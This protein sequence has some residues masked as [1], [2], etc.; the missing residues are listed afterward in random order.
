MSLPLATPRFVPARDVTALALFGAAMVTW[1]WL[2]F[3]RCV[4]IG[5]ELADASLAFQCCPTENGP[6]VLFLGDS[7]AVGCGAARPEDSIAGLLAQDF[8]HVTI[9]NRGCNGARTVEALAQLEAEPHPSYDAILIN[10]GGNDILKRTPFHTLPASAEALVAAARQRSE[11][12]IVTTTPNIG[13]V[14]M[15]FAPLSWW[16]TRRSRQLR[17]LFADVCKRHGA[18]YVNFFHP[19]SSDPFHREGRRFYAPDGLHPSTDCYRYVYATLRAG[20]PLA[21]VLAR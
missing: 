4:R 5:D 1:R 19:R 10:V 3:A 21:R 20:T 15:F 18:H 6:R 7:I 17:D 13:L 14:P 11:H 9:V 16:L 12:V 8:P 2:Q